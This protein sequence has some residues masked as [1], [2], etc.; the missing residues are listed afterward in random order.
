MKVAIVG[1][2]PAGFYTAEAVLKAVPG[3]EVDIIER[4]PTPFGLVRYG[5]APDH[6]SIKNIS[7]V[8][9]RTALSQTVR[10]F[11]HVTIGRDVTVPELLGLYDAVVMATGAPEDRHLGIPGEHLPGVVGSAAFVGWYNC[12]PDHVDLMPALDIEAAAVIGVGNVA[13][14]VARLLAK[15]AAELEGT[16]AH[17][18]ACEAIVKAPIRDIYVIGRRG[19]LD[20]TFTP[21]ELKEFGML[22][23]AVPLVDAAQLPADADSVPEKDHTA[24]K[25][26]LAIL[27]DYAARRPDEKP[28]RVHFLFYA[29]PVEVLGRERV[30]AL[31]LE[32][33]ALID[34]RVAGTGEV[35]TIPCGLV[36]P[37][38][39]YRTRRVADIP[40]NEEEGRFR[41]N[42]GHILPSLYATGWARRGPTGTIATNRADGQ[43]IA[44]EIARTGQADPQKTGRAGLLSLLKERGVEPVSFTDWQRIDAAE[45]EAAAGQGPRRK[46]M[47]VEEMLKA[48]GR[49]S[50]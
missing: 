30:E 13:L 3:A 1:S 34:G 21:Q 15:T 46:F 9:D 22:E 28:V 18:G 6:Q 41:N 39:G 48:L 45:Q 4:L 43:E 49:T 19:P 44:Q 50:C 2:G 17:P 14:D 5:V 20:A 25:K 27:Q 10:F 47:K 8:F 11:G 37:C 38:I 36:V 35:F 29:R 42:D 31:R 40:F 23:E 32:R 26:N 7:R 33:T 24:K 12:H 16:D